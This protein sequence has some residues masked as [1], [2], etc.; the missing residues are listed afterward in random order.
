MIPVPQLETNH[1][2][3]KLR[4]CPLCAA[5]RNEH[6]RG[7]GQHP[8]RL[9]ELRGGD[10]LDVRDRHPLAGDLRSPAPRLPRRLRE[11]D[12]FHAGRGWLL[13]L[14][15]PFVPYRPASTFYGKYAGLSIIYN[16]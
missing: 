14:N 2:L 1:V 15:A 9:H 16:F 7:P 4:P 12:G 11:E 8:R 5:L 3:E 10:G 13:K 6:V